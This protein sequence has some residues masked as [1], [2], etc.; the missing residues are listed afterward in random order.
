M[1][2]FGR[3]QKAAFG[4]LVI[5]GMSGLV[6][7]LFYFKNNLYVA[8]QN[9]Q[10]RAA[11]GKSQKD[12]K[13]L[14]DLTIEDTDKDG[15]KDYDEL[16]AYGTSP[17]LD[18]TDSDGVGDKEEIE[19]GEDPN[20][21]EGRECYNTNIGG[22]KNIVDLENPATPPPAV[23]NPIDAVKNLSV[24]DLRAMLGKSGIDGNILNQISDADLEKL[25]RDTIQEAE[26]SG[27]LDKAVDDFNNKNGE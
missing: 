8:S 21:P 11:K 15:L 14:V 4:L 18:D 12:A 17:F 13:S 10:E 25:Y 2:T 6:L 20:C 3:E 16:Y 7:G 5:L 19:K 1:P 22:K 9:A 27:E 26:K 24:K 23:L